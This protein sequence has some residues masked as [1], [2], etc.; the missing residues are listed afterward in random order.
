VLLQLFEATEIEGYGDRG[1]YHGQKINAEGDG[2]PGSINDPQ[3]NARADPRWSFDGT[4]ITYHQALTLAPD[5]G[6]INPLP[7]PVS[8]A[9]GGRAWRVMVAELTSRKP[10]PLPII[11]PISDY[12]PWGT[13]YIPGTI[14]TAGA[15]PALAPG[16]YTLYGK[17]S[18]HAKVQLIGSATTGIL[19]VDAVYSSYSDDGLN[20]INGAEHVT[21]KSA[22]YDAV[23][24]WYSNLTGTGAA[25]STKV[26][27]ADGFNLT[28]NLATNEFDA[29]GTLTTTVNG[30]VYRQ[31]CNFC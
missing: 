11:K 24:N 8:T 10:V 7:C 14:P 6:G 21:V 23:T 20:F 5:C 12:I 26:T 28:I 4:K 1:D 9:Q 17:S 18:G 13:P 16:N 22:G 15:G 19:T 29:N 3:W 25:N 27:S 30:A 2:S 31:P